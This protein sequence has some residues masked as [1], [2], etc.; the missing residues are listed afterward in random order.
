MAD[1]LIRRSDVLAAIETALNN[2]TGDLFDAYSAVK[3]IP[4]VT[5]TV[6]EAAKVRVKAAIADQI[7]EGIGAVLRKFCDSPDA[8]AARQYLHKMPESDWNTLIDMLAEESASA[9]LR[10]IAGESHD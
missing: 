3:T 1:D 7:S 5:P 4:A 9:A 8:A 10:A 6:Q 2:A